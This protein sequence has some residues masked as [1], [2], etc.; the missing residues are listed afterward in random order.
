M[1]SD[2]TSGWYS[3]L[4]TRNKLILVLILY[5]FIAVAVQKDHHPISPSTRSQIKSQSDALKHEWMYEVRQIQIE[6]YRLENQVKADFNRR[7]NKAR[8]YQREYQIRQIDQERSVIV[9][10]IWSATDQRIRETN[11][12]YK[13]LISA[14]EKRR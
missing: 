14:L 9:R 8:H 13:S 1:N 6:Q 12:I 5:V 3:R 2:V 11:E 7:I 4:S 10:Q